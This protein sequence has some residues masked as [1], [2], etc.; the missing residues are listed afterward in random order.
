M[1][2]WSSRVPPP[3]WTQQ[4]EAETTLVDNFDGS[5]KGVKTRITISYLCASSL[6]R[7]CSLSMKEDE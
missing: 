1:I 7:T 5:A 3:Q 6:N 4:L 2:F